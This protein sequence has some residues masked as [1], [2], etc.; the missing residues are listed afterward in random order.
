M[1]MVAVPVFTISVLV[2]YALPK[3]YR[4]SVGFRLRDTSPEAQRASFADQYANDLKDYVLR[5]P[6][7]LDAVARIN[8]YPQ[9]RDNPGGAAGLLGANT[10][11]SMQTGTIL[12]AGGHNQQIN[13]GFTVHFDH[14][15]PNIA[16]QVAVWLGESFLKGGR[17]DATEKNDET[18]AFL[19]QEADRLGKVVSD[20]EAKLADFKLRNFAQLPES[21]AA[22]MMAKNSAEQELITIDGRISQARQNVIYLKNQ[23]TT[24]QGSQGGN[25]AALQ[26]EYERRKVMLSTSHPEMIAL[27]Q[28]IE[29]ARN[30]GVIRVDGSLKSELDEKEQ[31]LAE[32]LRSY[33]EEY[34]EVKVLKREIESLKAR[35]K[36]GGR[37][38]ST[39]AVTDS[40]TSLNLKA[41]I[42]AAEVEL[43]SL[44]ARQAELR[45]KADQY[46]R[47]MVASPAVE[48]DYQSLVKDLDA[49]RLKYN[50]LVRRKLDVDVAT[51][52]IKA[53]TADKFAMSFAPSVPGGPFKPNRSL[54]MTLGLFA[55]VAAALG[56]AILREAFDGTVRGTKDVATLLDMSPLAV[57]PAIDNSVSRALFKRQIAIALTAFIVGVPVMFVLIRLAVR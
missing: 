30:G 14:E 29:R 19:G 7:R 15:D 31:L 13:T 1:V 50:E 2:A 11:L 8:P 39:A 46:Q 54:I 51:Q 27:Q 5:E 35:I 38:T 52:S 28:R 22:N 45:Y 55:A 25:L 33:S 47:Q 53:G 3:T 49:A 26:E 16:Y 42:N 23:L 12:D 57:V 24:L 34:P 20:A 40:A 48:R 56:A 43:N 36:A 6:N 44:Q 4:A 41:Q 37:D 21:A 17:Q 10:S 9:L 32:A 18:G